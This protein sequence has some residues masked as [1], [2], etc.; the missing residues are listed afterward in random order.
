MKSIYHLF[1][2]LLLLGFSLFSNTAKA[3]TKINLEGKSFSTMVTSLCAETYPPDPCAGY[4]DYMKLNFKKDQVEIVNER[5]Q[6]NETRKNVLVSKWS[7]L[8]G[9]QIKIE[10]LDYEGSP[11][12]T[13]NIL[14]LKNNQLTGKHNTR[15]TRDFVFEPVSVK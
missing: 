8:K 12:I 4:T 13:G 6:C 11:F 3:Q 1:T 15:F 5:V 14:V 7:Q 9:N 10:R 2:T